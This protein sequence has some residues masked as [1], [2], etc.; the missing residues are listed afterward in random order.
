[1]SKKQ[2][3]RKGRALTCDVAYGYRMG[4]GFPGDVNRG[5]STRIEP[6]KNHASTPV[7]KTGQAAIVDTATNTIRKFAAGD[8]AVTKVYGITTRDYPTQQQSASDLNA[9]FGQGTLQ[10]GQICGVLREGAMMVKVNAGTPTKDGAVFLWVAADSGNHVQGEFE[11]AAS[12][13]NTAAIA[14]MRFN[15]PPD[16]NGN[17]EV[18]IWQRD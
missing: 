1:M 17:V 7:P 14:N 12:A 11:T 8:T 15:G 10:A 13:G 16:A 5:V 2:A 18:Q 9:A 4:A 3:I 6:V